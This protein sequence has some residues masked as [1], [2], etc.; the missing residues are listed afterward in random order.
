VIGG[1]RDPAL[2]ARD[3]DAE[4]AASSTVRGRA[5]ASSSI[6]ASDAARTS[7]GWRGEGVTLERSTRDG[8]IEASSSTVSRVAARAGTARSRDIPAELR[9]TADA[10]A[11]LPRYTRRSDSSSAARHVAAAASVVTRPPTSSSSRSPDRSTVDARTGSTRRHRRRADLGAISLAG[12]RYVA[13]RA[14][15]HRSTRCRARSA[16]SP[17][18]GSSDA[19]QAAVVPRAP[20][21]YPPDLW[22][23]CPT[24]STMLFNKQLDKNLRVCTTCGHHFRLSAEARIEHLLDPGHGASAIPACSRSTPSDSSIS[25]RTRPAAAAQLATACATPRSGDRRHRRA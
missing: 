1:G 12:A 25:R 9:A 8:E 6:A 21:V 10:L 24:C 14:V 5:Y 17:G 2:R 19:A 15:G 4:I 7:P 11:A 18:P 23:K 3:V 16:R 22:T 20:D 13:W